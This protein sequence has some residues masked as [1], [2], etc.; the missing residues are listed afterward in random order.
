MQVFFTGKRQW[1]MINGGSS[2]AGRATCEG[3]GGGGG[4]AAA[5]PPPRGG[6]TRCEDP[7][8]KNETGCVCGSWYTNT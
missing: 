5:S 6:T 8:G 1:S 2:T 4:G 7:S 3:G